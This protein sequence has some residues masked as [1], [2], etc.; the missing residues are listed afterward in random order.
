ML[1]LK[2]HD[3]EDL[4]TKI[5]IR[6]FVYPQITPDKTCLINFRLS[7]LF[8]QSGNGKYVSSR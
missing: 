1:H 7:L 5:G 2:N 6:H 4:K 8:G 3:K